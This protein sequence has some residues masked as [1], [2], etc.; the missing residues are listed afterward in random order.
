MVNICCHKSDIL[1]DLPFT[2]SV[3]LVSS[4]KRRKC[5]SGKISQYWTA[6]ELNSFVNSSLTLSN[7]GRFKFK[8]YSLKS[9]SDINIGDRNLYV[10]DVS[11]SML[12]TRLLLPAL[13]DICSKHSIHIVKKHTTK[14]TLYQHLSTHRCTNCPAYSSVSILAE[15]YISST[16]RYKKFCHMHS[17]S[18]SNECE[19]KCKQT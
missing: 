15:E 2:R 9:Q 10:F 3:I 17:P 4:R 18:N 19:N 8:E 14:E 1:P 11:L 16:E 13:Y 6:T 5:G 12:A 7:Q